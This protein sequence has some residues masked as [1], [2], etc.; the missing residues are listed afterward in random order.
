MQFGVGALH[1][2]TQKRFPDTRPWKPWR[3]R[4]DPGSDQDVDQAIAGKIHIAMRV[5]PALAEATVAVVEPRYVEAFPDWSSEDE[6]FVYAAEA[7]LPTSPLFL[8]FEAVDGQPAAWVVESWP[9]PFHLRG[10]ACWQSDGVLSIV[11]F[12]SVGGVH[13]W[14]GTDYQAWARWAALQGSPP[15]WPDPGPGDF[16][17]RSTGEVR[18]WIDGESDSVCAQQGSVTFNLCHRV[19]GV[20]MLLES[21]GA[22][23]V[24]P[25]VSRP[26]KRRAKRE[27]KRIAWEP[28]G[29]PA[30]PQAPPSAID[31]A[32]LALN[33]VAREEEAPVEPCPIPKTHARLHQ[34]HSLWHGALAVYEDPDAF[35]VRLNALFQALRT[36]TWVLKKEVSKEPWF[37]DWYASWEG[38]MGAD[39]RMGW[40]LKSRNKI[41]KQGDLETHSVARVRLT[42][43]L[44]EGERPDMEVDPTAPPHEIARLIATAGLPD[45]V[46]RHGTLVVERRWTVEDLPNDEILDALAH[47]YG[48]LLTIVIEAHERTDT[49]FVG[50]E[51]E[52]DNPCPLP[53]QPHPSGRLPCM[54]AGRE[55]R[56]ARRDLSSGLLIEIESRPTRGEPVASEEVRQHYGALDWERPPE[57]GDLYEQA[58]VRHNWGRQMLGV[59]GYHHTIAW[60]FRGDVPLAQTALHPQ[61]QREKQLM[62]E[63]LARQANELG[64]DGLIF[65]TEAWEAAEVGRDDPGAKLRPAEREDRRE[66]FVTYCVRRDEPCRAWR[67]AM[68]RCSA[69]DEEESYK[70]EEIELGE[71][72]SFELDSP[73]FLH[74]LLAVWEE[75]PDR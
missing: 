10:A 6:P 65:S 43:D 60:L 61:D 2:E 38:R 44:F 3:F 51:A 66:A 11:P 36:V 18:S 53:Q 71:V 15:D 69:G 59:D 35:V 45:D 30:A 62:M 19:L 63:R 74:P 31:Q 73:P 46:R 24:Q 41:E 16:L 28:E 20:L 7:S 17:T 23:L 48:V 57:G 49:G 67:S 68:T 1:P 12:G 27:G 50:C 25:T 40:A 26:V 37:A 52:Q 54:L 21:L 42:G 47:C 22:D 70:K 64:A 56:T 33:V 8:D 4:P 39:R 58:R 14:G 72:S 13:P 29:L 9:L 5:L 32:A 34:A 55:A 75:W